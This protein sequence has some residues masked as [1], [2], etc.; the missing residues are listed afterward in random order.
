VPILLA[1][2]VLDL[3]RQ[4]LAH[5][6]PI[7]R[8]EREHARTPG[9]H[10]SGVLVKVA[11]SIGVLKPGEPIEEDLPLRVVAGHMWEEFAVSLYPGI[12]WQ[13]GETCVDGVWMTPDGLEADC[14]LYQMIGGAYTNPNPIIRADA[15]H[16]FKCTWKKVRSG[17]DLLAEWYWMAQGKGYCKGYGVRHV[18]W[19]V[20]Y[21]NGD[22]HNSGPIYKTY[23]VEFSE[24]EIEQSWRMVLNHKHLAVPE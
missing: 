22:Y 10:L 8:P 15:L 12:V 17:P 18:K 14:Y 21:V 11:E 19:H 23:T 7:H 13:P 24:K 6:S 3:Q 5:R 1:E 20:F 2:S 16:E 4:D 9:V